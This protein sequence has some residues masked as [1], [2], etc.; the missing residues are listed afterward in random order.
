MNIAVQNEPEGASFK[1]AT[2]NI[3]VSENP[4]E[5]PEDGVIATYPAID[6][7]TG[8]PSEDVSYAK[9][10]DPDNLLM[11]DPETAEIKL[12]RAPDRESPFVV[13]GTY[14]A[15]V[16]A[17]AAGQPKTATGTIALQVG[18]V[19]DNCPSL[20]STIEY[21]CTDTQVIPIAGH[22][23]DGD[24]NGGPFI[25]KLVSESTQGNWELQNVT[26]LDAKLVAL[27]PLWPGRYEVMIQI[28]DQQGLSC[29]EPQ[30]LEIKACQCEEGQSC[31]PGRILKMKAKHKESG[32]GLGG[33]GA[34]FLGLVALLVAAVLLMTCGFGRAPGAFSDI[35]IFTEDHL[36][37]YHTEGQGE[38]KEFP[39][40]ASPV[41]MAPSAL[42]Q[43]VITAKSVQ[44]TAKANMSSAF[45]SHM[46][47]FEVGGMRW[48]SSR[49]L[50]SSFGDSGQSQG[51]VSLMREGRLHV[52]SMVDFALPDMFLHGYY[53]EKS[54][55]V[56]T[57]DPARDSL[58]VYEFEG[59]GS[60]AGSIDCIGSLE[61]DDDLTFLDNLELKFKTL[62]DL[63]APPASSPLPAVRSIH[64]NPPMA[65]IAPTLSTMRESTNLTRTNQLSHSQNF[66][67]LSRMNQQSAQDTSMTTIQR[68]KSLANLTQDAP[69]RSLRD[70]RKQSTS[71]IQLPP[72]SPPRATIAPP[73]SHP[74]IMQ[75]QPIYY[76]TS[77]VMQPTS[78]VFQPAMHYVVQPPM[79][80]TMVFADPQAANMQGVVLLQNGFGSMEQM[81][82][83]G[84][85]AMSLG[86][87]RYMSVIDLGQHLE[88]EQALGASRKSGKNVSKKGRRMSESRL[89]AAGSMSVLDIGRHVEAERL[90]GSQSSV[91]N[92]RR[93]S[94]DWVNSDSYANMS[95]SS[96]MVN[97]GEGR[98]RRKTRNRIMS[99]AEL[100]EQ[101]GDDETVEIDENRHGMCRSSLQLN[102]G[103]LSSLQ[104]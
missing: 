98:A 53:A 16:F 4:D 37:V 29:P 69:L 88:A 23:P 8:K 72:M 63:C 46:N 64:Q 75:Q 32:V 39:L 87:R 83:P 17:M 95:L 43:D 3:P 100:S 42:S 85:R 34:A 50:K 2:M 5:L 93:L 61:V 81:V 96:T 21:L 28:W 67:T 55:C 54:S 13:N 31:A 26:G 84:A 30:V 19:N 71:I 27:S 65:S 47:E 79:Q 6:E 57:K 82:N 59:R 74:M 25:F 68:S 99:M 14:I 66:S 10:Y 11:I 40:L 92:G 24:P 62:A 52:E 76:I 103:Y 58:L 91:L 38:D 73:L 56:T 48:G 104:F 86:G 80:N 22:D 77:P 9:G 89:N 33:L 102:S 15:K 41:H 35:P 94:E 7:D 101:V 45:A 90:P 20:N 51:E 60:L 18:D 78:P 97:S 12:M 44:N 36:M 49:N 1:P 70:Q